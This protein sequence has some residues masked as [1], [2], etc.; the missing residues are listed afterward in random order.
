MSRQLSAVNTIYGLRSP[1]NTRPPL[2]SQMTTV[3]PLA[4]SL[5]YDA[6]LNFDKV[7]Q[8]MPPLAFLHGSNMTPFRTPNGN[9]VWLATNTPPSAKAIIGKCID[10]VP[11]EGSLMTAFHKTFY[12]LCT[13]ARPYEAEAYIGEN[14]VPF[15]HELSKAMYDFIMG[16]THPTN[17]MKE[18]M[19]LEFFRRARG[20]IPDCWQM[21]DKFS[22]AVSTVLFRHCPTFAQGASAHNMEANCHHYICI[23]AAEALQIE[24]PNARSY[25]HWDSEKAMNAIFHSGRNL[26]TVDPTAQTN[27]VLDPTGPYWGDCITLARVPTDYPVPNTDT[28]MVL[29]QA[30]HAT[31]DPDIPV[32]I[33]QHNF[34]SGEEHAARV[35]KISEE[36][37]EAWQD[38][39]TLNR[40]HW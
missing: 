11:Q 29:S 16:F 36:E 33:V 38:V 13:K 6:G 23:I 20:V 37:Y 10:S 21:N 40:Y 34:E 1:S 7:R 39:A 14:P 22:T 30:N 32:D 26:G 15:N 17:F 28:P 24:H 35:A 27:I 19:F 5:Q 4:F 18:E 3:L 31:N 12:H 25:Y 9:E 2:M 8:F